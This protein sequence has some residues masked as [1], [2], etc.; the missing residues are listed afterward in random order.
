MLTQ[1]EVPLHNNT[2]ARH[3]REYVTRRKVSGGTRSDAGRQV[4]DTFTSLKKTCGCLGVSFWEY[5][6]DR[7]GMRGVVPR[8]AELIRD[9]AAR[10]AAGAVVAASA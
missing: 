8:L 9:H 1:P 10:V 7:V 2:S 4:R 5:V 6:P 3:I